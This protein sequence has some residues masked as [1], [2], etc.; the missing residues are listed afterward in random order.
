MNIEFSDLS[1]REKARIRML[2]KYNE[3]P[4]YRESKLAYQSEYNAKHREA[5]TEYQ[6][7]YR[8]ANREKLRKYWAERKRK[9]Y[10][11]DPAFREHLKE[12]ARVRASTTGR[13]Y[14]RDYQNMRRR[15]D[16]QY[17]LTENL[18][19]RVRQ[20]LNGQNKSSATLKMLGCSPEELRVHLAAKFKPG[21]TWENYGEWHID[22]IVPCASFDM[23]SK[24]QQAKCFHYTNL[25]PLWGAEN[26][27]K[28]DAV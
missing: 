13:K 28:G 8:E 24:E 17:K 26:Q 22:H 9:K 15:T 23:S 10:A 25:Q 20:A 3:D 1:N 19:R 18:R 5:L 14:H 4:A 27:S 7:K 21:M 2:K 16:P 6:R 12:K 11:E